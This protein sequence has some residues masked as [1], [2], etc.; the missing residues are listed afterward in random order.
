MNKL[1]WPFLLLALLVTL[2]I[3]MIELSAVRATNVAARLPWFVTGASPGEVSEAFGAFTPEQ[4]RRLQELQREKAAEIQNLEAELS[5][6]GV[7]SLQF[8]DGF[9]LFTLALMTLALVLPE[10]LQAKVQGILTAIFA[11]VV[12]LAGIVKGFLV[13]AKLLLMVAMLLA[14]PFGTLAYLIIYGSFPR[15]AGN[16]VLALIFLLKF[17]VVILLL[18]AHQRFAENKGLVIFIL[19]AFVANLIV[20]LLYGIVPGFLVSITDA[21]AA[22]VVIII[23]V[24]LAIILLILAIISIILALKPV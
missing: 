6:Y 23:G 24:I 21:I 7:E 11:I 14:F 19:L 4:A 1:R 8:V 2:V 15:A 17:V 16:A 18:L 3:V 20:S 12:I 10:Y 9:L 22:L 5:G 13:L